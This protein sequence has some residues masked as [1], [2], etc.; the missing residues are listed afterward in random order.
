MTS[1]QLFAVVTMTL[2]AVLAIFVMHS[3]ASVPLKP[4][5][6]V[7]YLTYGADGTRACV[8]KERIG[9]GGNPGCCPKG[10]S[11]AGVRMNGDVGDVVC[12]ER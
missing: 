3:Q 1:P 10:F 6:T 4:A 8:G 12:L 11:L 5:S 2:I 7:I 9:Y